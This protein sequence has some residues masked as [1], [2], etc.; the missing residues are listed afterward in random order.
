MFDG[1]AGRS[2][3]ADL[4]F[5][6]LLLYPSE[7]QPRNSVI[8]GFQILLKGCKG[9]RSLFFI[10]GYFHSSR[11]KRSWRFAAVLRFRR[12]GG[13]RDRSAIMSALFHVIGFGYGRKLGR[14]PA[15]LPGIAEHHLR[16]AVVFAHWAM[17][18]DGLTDKGADISHVAQI[19]CR[20]GDRKAALG[21]VLAEAEVLSAA[22]TLN[23]FHYFGANT[24]GGA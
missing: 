11:R 21:L 7:L 16:A 6:K 22:F 8:A 14:L 24:G 19:V 13:P 5:R 12:L 10:L 3:T 18:L 20:N 2:R 17:Y 9:Y 15:K 23:D 4:E 1:G